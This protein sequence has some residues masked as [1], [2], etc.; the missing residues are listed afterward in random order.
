MCLLLLFKRE[1]FSELKVSNRRINIRWTARFL[2][3][4][5]LVR[6]FLLTCVRR[7]NSFALLYIIWHGDPI[8]FVFFSVRFQLES[9][10]F[11]TRVHSFSRVRASDNLGENWDILMKLGTPVP[12]HSEEVGW[13]SWPRPQNAVNRKPIKCYN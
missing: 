11:Y 12:C 2:I 6:S 9:I 10:I 13:P 1:T 7:K 3:V 8:L 5:S 4:G